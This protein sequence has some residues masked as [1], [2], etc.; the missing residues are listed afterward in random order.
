MHETIELCTAG[1]MVVLPGGVAISLP[2][3][4]WSPGDVRDMTEE[5]REDALKILRAQHEAILKHLK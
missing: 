2:Y 5:D 3:M 4:P 1:R